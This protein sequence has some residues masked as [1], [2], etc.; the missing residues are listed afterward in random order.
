MPFG[1][2]ATFSAST[3]LRMTNG[4]GT[5]L[6]GLPGVPLLAKLAR[7]LAGESGSP[8]GLLNTSE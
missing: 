8:S 4:C 7:Q 5:L 2:E 6:L 3:S 1:T